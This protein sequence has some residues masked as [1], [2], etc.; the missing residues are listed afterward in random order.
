[1]LVAAYNQLLRILFSCLCASFQPCIICLSWPQ[2]GELGFFLEPVSAISEAPPQS[3]T[4]STNKTRTTSTLEILDGV[5]PK[6]SSSN[7]GVGI[8]A[9]QVTSLTRPNLFVTALEQHVP[10]PPS[11]GQCQVAGGELIW[12]IISLHSLNLA[13]IQGPPQTR[14][15]AVQGLAQDAAKVSEM[16]SVWRGA[17]WISDCVIL[18]QC[19]RCSC[20]CTASMGMAGRAGV[21]PASGG[22]LGKS[23]RGCRLL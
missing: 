2:L 8:H 11:M 9:P 5:V 10:S 18:L 19:F 7:R 6:C 16:P 14:R 23:R 15:Q 4:L 21:L 20:V 3:I 22:A 12:V 1:M 13:W 17:L